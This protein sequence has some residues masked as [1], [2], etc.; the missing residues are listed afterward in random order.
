MATVE[1]MV[2]EQ[3]TSV[4]HMG[5]STEDSEAY[6]D[7]ITIGFY[8]GGDGEVFLDQ[9]GLRVQIQAHH[10][11]TII[12]QLQRAH[13]LAMEAEATGKEG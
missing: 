3:V 7:P 13:K 8:R 2:M 9:G 6:I 12:K 11:K 1:F 5:C 4:T 10:L